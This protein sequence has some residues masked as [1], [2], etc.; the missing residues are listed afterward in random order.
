MEARRPP[1]GLVRLLS[2][3]IA[4]A[5]LIGAALLSPF[6]LLSLFSGAHVDWALL[7]DIGQTYGAV[8]AVLSAVALAVLAASLRLQAR[9]V[10]HG[11]EH[12]VLVAHQAVMRMAIEDPGLHSCFPMPLGVGPGEWRK[13]MY[14]NL[15]VSMWQ[16]SWENGGLSGE[17]LRYLARNDLFKTE[18]GRKFWAISGRRRAPSGRRG[19]LFVR[20]IDEEY[21]AA[22]GAGELTPP[23]G[24]PT[25]L[26]SSGTDTGEGFSRFGGRGS[27]SLALVGV[28][29]L[30][31]WGI[32][33]WGGK[34]L[35]HRRHSS[36]ELRGLP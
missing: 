33:R 36:P 24:G 18:V 12:A 29:F 7:G 14:L 13:I 9:E 27:A 5:L 34:P 6:A 10:R 17:H 11:R 35:A 8:S 19:R 28:G 23:G 32:R 3:N 22:V 15:L 31:G 4:V 30:V 2:L 20:I 1:I 21:E 25:A 26:R 16:V